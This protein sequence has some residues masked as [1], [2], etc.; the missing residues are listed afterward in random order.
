MGLLLYIILWDKM[1]QTQHILIDKVFG[2][3][4]IFETQKHV[5]KVMRTVTLHS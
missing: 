3:E 5:A 2:S 4:T 1:T